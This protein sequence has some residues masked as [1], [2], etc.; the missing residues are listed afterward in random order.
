MLLVQALR[1]YGCKA[2]RTAQ[3]LSTGLGRPSVLASIGIKEEA[4]TDDGEDD[5]M[6]DAEGPAQGTDDATRSSATA[7]R[8]PTEFDMSKSSKRG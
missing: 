6:E 2:T 4:G 3:R 5:D 8:N 1:R 7:A